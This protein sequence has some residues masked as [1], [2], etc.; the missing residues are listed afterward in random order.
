MSSNGRIRAQIVR[1][2]GR[3]VTFEY[4][5]PYVSTRGG[6][7]T[8]THEPIGEEP[9][10]QS[11][12]PAGETVEIS[13]NCY[14]DE[15]NFLSNLPEGAE[16]DVRTDRWVGEGLVDTVSVDPTGEGGGERPGVR[17]RV[18]EYRL[19]FYALDGGAPV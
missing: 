18:Y 13:G 8:V 15:A 3:T 1:S 5:Y 11:L 12:G 2:D 14:L 9:V 17:N 19:K 6:T 16:I 7:N 4:E 10:H